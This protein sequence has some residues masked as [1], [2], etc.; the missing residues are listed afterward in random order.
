MTLA[1]YGWHAFDPEPPGLRLVSCLASVNSSE[2]MSQQGESREQ[3]LIS[4]GQAQAVHQDKMGSFFQFRSRH[5]HQLAT[6]SQTEGRGQS[7]AEGRAL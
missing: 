4:G 2:E 1:K 5:R 3:S 7:R 6:V